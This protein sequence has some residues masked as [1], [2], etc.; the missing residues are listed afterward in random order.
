MAIHVVFRVLS[1]LAH[2]CLILAP[3]LGSQLSSVE[4]IQFRLGTNKRYDVYGP[5]L[6]EEAEQRDRKP[7]PVSLPDD[8]VRSTGR[9]RDEDRLVPVRALVQAR[10]AY[11]EVIEVALCL[12][13]RW[14]MPRLIRSGLG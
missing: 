11:D 1:E 13:P 3:Q 2:D 8:I 6:A 14:L 4:G 12:A 10:V 9:R 7:H 5:K